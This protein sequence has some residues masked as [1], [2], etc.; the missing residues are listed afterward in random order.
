MKSELKNKI[1]FPGHYT[2]CYAGLVHNSP[3]NAEFILF[4]FGNFVVPE[5]KIAQKSRNIHFCD[6]FVEN[7]CVHY[8]SGRS[9][10]KFY[11]PHEN[12]KNK[13]YK[14][15]T[16]FERNGAKIV[17]VLDLSLNFLYRTTKFPN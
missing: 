11:S 7:T 2:E 12:F 17:F 5:K 16:I 14:N 9:T 8:E 1:K 3:Y 10:R 6:L 4:Q 13:K 15:I